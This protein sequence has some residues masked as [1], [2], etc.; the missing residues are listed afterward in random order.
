MLAP[1]DRL[2]AG[3][4][5]TSPRRWLRITRSPAGRVS[6]LLLFLLALAAVLAG[7]L[8]P[9]PPFATLA[10]P[11]LPPSGA[12]PM[13]TDDLGRDV[14]SGVLH[15]DR[16][17]LIV[18]L[19]VTAIA[20]TIGIVIGL[21]S[22]FFGAVA[23]TLLMRFTDLML[24]VP[25]LFLGIVVLAL[26]G[27]GLGRVILVLGLTSWP[28]L[29]R[30]VRAETL[31]L[32]RQGFVEA[33]TAAGAPYPRI[34]A[35]HILPNA[36]P[37]AVVVVSLNAGA[38][39]LLEAGISFLGLGDP[40]AMSWG[41]L[42]RNAQAFLSVAWWMAVFPG[43]AIALAVLA[44]NLLGDALN[45]AIRPTAAPARGRGGTRSWKGRMTAL[46]GGDGGRPARPGVGRMRTQRVRRWGRQ[47]VPRRRRSNGARMYC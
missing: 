2:A 13:G 11:L 8:S 4:P 31:S 19:A 25:R 42:A 32:R 22:G 27:P 34:L 29:A 33:A 28:E 18:V 45:D 6:L 12:H 21:V 30:V 44:F 10:P 24:A 5:E 3:R 37:A 40:N 1:P 26:L 36:L 23:D 9:D 15:G 41:Y 14:L 35:M 7:R 38:V 47:G 39:V 46:R 16:T 43:V 20:G 17:S